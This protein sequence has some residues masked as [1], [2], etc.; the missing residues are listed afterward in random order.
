LAPNDIVPVQRLFPVST[1]FWGLFLHVYRVMAKATGNIG[2]STH[3][4]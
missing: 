1:S 3:A 2:T 4:R